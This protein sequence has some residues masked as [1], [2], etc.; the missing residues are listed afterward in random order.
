MDPWHY[1]GQL[2]VSVESEPMELE[3]ERENSRQSFGCGSGEF[4][5]ASF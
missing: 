1:K 2:L 4:I 3:E 5:H